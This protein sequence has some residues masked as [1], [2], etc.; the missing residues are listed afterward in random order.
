MITLQ[1]SFIASFNNHPVWILEIENSRFEEIV[2]NLKIDIAYLVEMIVDV[3]DVCES[4]F[5]GY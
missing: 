3:L 1:Y 5:A 2:I 4:S